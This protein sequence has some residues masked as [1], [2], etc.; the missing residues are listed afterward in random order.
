MQLNLGDMFQDITGVTLVPEGEQSYI[1]I[2]SNLEQ[3]SKGDD[4]IVAEFEL[5]HGDYEGE[6]L[7]HYFAFPT[8]SQT[9]GISGKQKK[10]LE[11][12]Y[13]DFKMIGLD[14][15]DYA[16]K[17]MSHLAG[18]MIGKRGRCFIH[19]DEYQGRKM[20]KIKTFIS[21]KLGTSQ[22]RKSSGPPPPP[23]KNENTNKDN[24]GMPEEP[25]FE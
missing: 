13:Q 10:R 16:D 4:M 11:F 6:I 22:A 3:T 8:I 23:T 2:N 1:C 18:D 5:T 9:S 17:S 19:H 15:H 20:A 25:S 12:L 7:T 24:E 14:L 21:P